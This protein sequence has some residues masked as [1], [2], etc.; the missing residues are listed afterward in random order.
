[1]PRAQPQLYEDGAG[2]GRR[3]KS[4][5][6]LKKRFAAGNVSTYSKGSAKRCRTGF[7]DDGQG[8]C[9]KKEGR[10]H[11]RKKDGSL[12]MRYAVNRVKSAIEK[13]KTK[14][15]KKKYVIRG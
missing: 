4:K 5:A 6:A 12:D 10:I 11:M 7:G 13:A 1:M 14:N 8:S 9:R 3:A 2:V 15:K